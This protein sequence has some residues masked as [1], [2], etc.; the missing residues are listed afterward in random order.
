METLDDLMSDRRLLTVALGAFSLGE[1][2]DKGAFV[3]KIL[4]EG[5]ED[6]SSFAVRLNNSDYLDLANTFVVGDNGE[7]NITADTAADIVLKY[8][9]ESFEEELGDVDNSMRLA[10]NF[11]RVIADFASQGLSENAGWFK[12][13]ASTPIRTVLESAFNLPDGFSQLDLDFQKEILADKAK[14]FYGGTTVDVFNDPDVIENTIR[15]YL[16]Q[17]QIE[18]GPSASTPGFAAI[19]ILNGGLGSTGIT[20][21]LLSNS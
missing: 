10:L 11:K 19:S 20:N 3:R 6:N 8:Q 21:L 13:M 15:R 4:E 16:L 9:T 17:E 1:E 5:T 14:E 12:A 18:L 2:I 7:L